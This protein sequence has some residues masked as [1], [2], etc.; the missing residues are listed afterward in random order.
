[1]FVYANQLS[2]EGPD[3][4]EAVFRGIGVWLKE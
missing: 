4:E 3:A 2:F 1:M